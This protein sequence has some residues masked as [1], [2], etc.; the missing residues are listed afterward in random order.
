MTFEI[1]PSTPASKF[2]RKGPH[3][4][5]A[6]P[7]HS[8]TI[9]VSTFNS[10]M[11]ETRI[12]GERG[13]K[14]TVMPLTG[15]ADIRD[16]RAIYVA[17]FLANPD[18]THLFFV[19]SDVSWLP[20]SMVRLLA[21]D[22]EFVAGLYPSRS[23]PLTFPF[24]SKNEPGEEVRFD[25]AENGLIELWG[26]PAG[27]VCLKRSM[28]ERMVKEYAHT[29]FDIG[30]RK[31]GVKQAWDLFETYR[32]P[33]EPNCKLSEDYAFCQRWRDIGGKVLVDPSIGM[34]HTGLKV[35]VGK[36]GEVQ[37]TPSSSV[38]TPPLPSVALCIPTRGRGD[39][40]IKTVTNAGEG[41][42]HPLTRILIAYDDDDVGDTLPVAANE[43]VITTVSAREDSVGAKYNR[44]FRAHEAD[45]YIQGADDLL[46][47][48]GWDMAIAQTATKFK[49][50]IGVVY[51]GKNL[52]MDGP[53]PSGGF[54][55]TKRFLDLMG[56]FPEFSPFWWYDTWVSEIA[57]MIDRIEWAPVDAA[58]AGGT[59]GKTRG[60]R[61][62]SFW[63][64]L[65]AALRPK[66]AQ[67]ARNMINTMI[68]S[69]EERKALLDGIPAMCKKFEQEHDN[70][71]DQ[72]I[73]TRLET[74]L[75]YDAPADERYLR[76]RQK[77][78]ELLYQ[79]KPDTVLGARP[80]AVAAE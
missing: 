14:S 33:D 71:C 25:I 65:F 57:M 72:E 5:I 4:L 52:P 35:F 18:Y 31:V 61:D 27:F 75:S 70:L 32:L 38:P 39:T 46:H 23:E 49:D 1:K 42:L 47:A 22:V 78:I 63:Q 59:R 60:L 3:V 54:A 37:D 45:I 43:R 6:L 55:V 13:V 68:V 62:A 34:G 76:I 79:L 11:H 53:L 20:G 66:R 26:V 50:G 40:L 19:D 69:S 77:G 16:I 7:C 28:L 9:T 24:R 44:L 10:L 41:A 67:I 8:G 36:L 12:F 58:L 2:T 64:T 15:A 30:M 51:L 29:V 17:E 80:V 56:G 21:H 73:A 48:S 74:M